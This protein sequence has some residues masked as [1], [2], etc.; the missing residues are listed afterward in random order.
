MKSF[1]PVVVVLCAL[2]SHLLCAQAAPKPSLILILADDMGYGDIGPFGSVK[3]RTPN[4]DRMA[5]EGVKFTSFYAAPVCT[6]SR[7]QILTGC[8]AK[9]VSLPLVL[10]PAAPIGLSAREHSI[11]ELLK[12]QGYATIAIGKWHV[13]DQPEFLP[14]RHG[15][16]R[17]FGLPYSN[18]MGGPTNRVQSETGPPPAAAARGKR[19]SHR[20][21]HARR[22]K[23]ADRALHR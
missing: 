21:R 15:F 10:S 7:A 17:Y 18:D 5:R 12:Q 19:P 22:P 6:P 11:A 4:L 3:N 14:T 20:D 8:Y 23:P 2:A 13:G 9:R 1:P 16:D